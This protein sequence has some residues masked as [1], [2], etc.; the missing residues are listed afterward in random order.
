MI[1]KLINALSSMKAAPGILL[2]LAALLAM[3][4]ENSPL[5]GLYGALK[6]TPVV[7]QV[8]AFI[9]D[10]P[11]LLWINDGLM[12]IFFLLVGLEIKRE[13]LEGHLS[14]REQF[15][16]PAIAAA[17]GVACPA[18]IYA[19]VNWGDPETLQGWAIPAATDI[20]FA[21]GILMLLGR[22]VPRALVIIL[23][24][25]AVI[26][27]LAAIVI[28]AIFYTHDTSLLSLG[29]ALVGLAALYVLNRKGVTRLGPYTIIGLFIWACVL[30]SGVHATLA[31]VAIG[32]LIPLR[33][34]N[35]HGQ[36]P[37]KVMEH[38][39][40]PWVGLAILPVFA[41]ANAGVSLAGLGFETFLHPITLGTTLGLFFGK[42]IGVMG[43]TALAVFTGICRLPQS[44]T[45]LQFYGM[46]LMTGIGFTMSLFIGTLAFT[47]VENASAVRL[48]V[49]TGSFLS[50]LAGAAV[51]LWGTRNAKA[52]GA[53]DG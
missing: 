50:A 12:A 26:D 49:L 10:K 28:I 17:G 41:F 14:S 33:A 40:H 32:F 36:S 42:Q 51:L 1:I 43:A 35:E 15:V 53:H 29:L 44:V 11:L 30:K 5:S 13:V 22:R 34:E 39:L 31:G 2:F 47:H 45:W 18:L 38:A 52:I 4:M 8:G 3:F 9:I 23:M 24:A 27:D 21:L 20:A 19:Y 7:L 37:L 25:I 46:A 16:L 6:D 48:G